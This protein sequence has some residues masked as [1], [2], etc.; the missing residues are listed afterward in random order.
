LLSLG[1]R[2][3]LEGARVGVALGD[4]G[5]AAGAVHVGVVVAGRREHSL[6]LA[7]VQPREGIDEPVVVRSVGT[8]SGT[9]ASV[10]AVGRRSLKLISPSLARSAS[11][12]PGPTKI[13]LAIESKG[14]MP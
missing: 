6:V 1:S 4:A 9:P 11:I 12:M 14:G 5:E 8:R 7:D 10:I 2:Y 13:G 3:R